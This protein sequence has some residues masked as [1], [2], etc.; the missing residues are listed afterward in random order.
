MGKGYA[1]PL[2][3]FQEKG[4]NLEYLG[5]SLSGGKLVDSKSFIK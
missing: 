1:G 4:C 5:D 3:F 2:R